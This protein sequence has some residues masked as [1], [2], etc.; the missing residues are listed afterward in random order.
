MW[1]K[2]D[3]IDVWF[4]RDGRPFDAGE[5]RVA[6]T[7]FPPSPQTMVGALRAMLI[8]DRL[9]DRVRDYLRWLDPKK[10]GSSEPLFEQVKDEL[11]V[12]TKTGR[13]ALR[14]PFVLSRE[15][16]PLL[17]MPRDV[18]LQ[19]TGN[20]TAFTPDSRPDTV[21]VNSDLR[22]NAPAGFVP[23]P[24]TTVSD[25]L[26]DAPESGWMSLAVFGNYLLGEPTEAAP[27]DLPLK[28]ET[29]VGI[30][31]D[32]NRQT[33]PGYYYA[34]D[35]IRPERD[36]DGTS[37]SLL[38]QVTPEIQNRQLH[39]AV[40]R[41]GGEGRLAEAHINPE[42]S[43]TSD[44]DDFLDP[45]GDLA[46]Q[47]KRKLASGERIA[48][49]VLLQPAAFSRGWRP[50]VV[51]DDGASVVRAGGTDYSFRLVSAS[52]AKPIAVSGWN[53]VNTR[54]KPLQYAARV[55]SVYFFALVGA[56]EVAER[57]EAWSAF[58]DA[59]HGTNGLLGAAERAAGYGLSVVGVA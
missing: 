38:A 11:G 50:N 12:G 48:R 43:A 13:M 7:Q 19:T 51:E 2:L 20:M 49:V 56:F 39:R 10:S 53:S 28:L 14:G 58:V 34:K 37:M 9:G 22:S 1:I 42:I 3:P 17:P 31:L 59:F 5:S 23:A 6:S 26:E 40:I 29:H 4:F 8:D 45:C 47:V 27:F 46:T 57:A 21:L 52:I 16:T 55:G 54:A 36:S 41:F 32:E 44:L 15:H 35:M 30:A 24:L 33:R 18:M 25:T